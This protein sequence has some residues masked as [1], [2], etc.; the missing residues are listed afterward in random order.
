MKRFR[1][2]WVDIEGGVYCT[3]DIDAVDYTEASLIA[4]K[5]VKAPDFASAPGELVCPVDAVVS[6]I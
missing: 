6:R 1:I 3:A 4:S 2:E 5:I